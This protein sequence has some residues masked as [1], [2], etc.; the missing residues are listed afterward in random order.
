MSGDLSSNTT[1]AFTHGTFRSGYLYF[2][3]SDCPSENGLV[4]AHNSI[5]ILHEDHKKSGYKVPGMLR[6]SIN[7][8]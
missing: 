1:S 5:V 3:A 8:C 4:I 6:T 7:V 2:Y